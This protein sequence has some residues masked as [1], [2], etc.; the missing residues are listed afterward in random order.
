[1]KLV[2]SLAIIFVLSGCSMFNRRSSLENVHNVPEWVTEPMANCREQFE[3]CASGEG[4]SL[5]L[6][7]LNARKAMASIF[8]TEVTSELTSAATT[9]GAMGFDDPKLEEKMSIQL[10]EKV[11]QLLEG[12]S[13]RERAQV[14]GVYF[15]LAFLDKMQ[16]WKKLEKEIDEIDAQL[17][18]MKKLKRRS[19]LKK[20]YALYDLRGNLNER[21]SFLRGKSLPQKVTL[22][23]IKE[24]QFGESSEA[25]K[26]KFEIS[27]D[28]S[29]ETF[30]HLETML[31][32]YG[33]KI[34][35]DDE[36]DVKLSGKVEQKQEYMNVK[37]FKKFSFV[38]YLVTRNK[39][40]S[41]IGGISLKETS[42]GRDNKDA[43]LKIEPK[44]RDYIEEHINELNID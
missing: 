39:K 42:I 28:I 27:A 17:I 11:D 32:G 40:G 14:D 3:L 43:Y 37:G 7:D 38:F 21:Y 31:S 13:I 6:A 10:T 25:K 30:E 8:E 19:S 1:M 15:A 5:S 22:A 16:A 44:I 18:E 26:I 20:M 2:M 34:V 4:V 9:Y 33:H 23:D 35:S 41:K 29:E 24:I 36:Y 12:V